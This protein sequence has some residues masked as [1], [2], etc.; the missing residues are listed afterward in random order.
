MSLV[1]GRLTKSEVIAVVPPGTF[2]AAE[3]YSRQTLSEAVHQKGAEIIRLVSCARSAKEGGH[4]DKA[5]VL[6]R[7]WKR[8]DIDERQT[9]R[10]MGGTKL[11]I[12]CR[13][14]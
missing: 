14:R 11:L 1:I 7:R 6:K 12:D 2:S 5:R 3:A 8:Q 4:M 13:S 10:H 9:K